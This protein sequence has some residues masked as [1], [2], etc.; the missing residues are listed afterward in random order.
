[1][2]LYIVTPSTS[3]V[4]IDSGSLAAG[5]SAI[6]LLSSQMPPGR[7]VT[8]RDSTGY[9]STPQS[10]IVSTTTGIFFA[11]GTSSIQI[12]QP[13]ASLS[14]TSRSATSWNV[15]NTFG[16]PLYNTV[17]NVNSLTASTITGTTLTLGG[18]VS[19]AYFTANSLFLQSTTQVLGAAFVS[20]LVVGTQ[21]S[22]SIPYQ[23]TPGYAAY[24]IGSAQI[25]SNAVFGGNLTVG[26]SAQ[27]Q[28]S[29]IVSGNLGVAQSMTV[30]AD[31]TIQGNLNTIGNGI[32]NAQTIN[33]QSS[34]SIVGPAIF[35]SNL[36]V[37]SNLQVAGTTTLATLGTST[38]NIN[39][40]AGGFLQL[41]SGPI[42][43]SV[44]NSTGQVV[45]SW[46]A[47]IY[48]PYLS[49]GSVQATTGAT[50]G[51]LQV[52]NTI[53]AP[54][55]S[56]VV[57]GSANIQNNAGSLTISS[58]NTN[59]LVLSNNIVAQ[60]FTASTL[61]ASTI[62]LGGSLIGVSPLSQLSTA[63]A[64]TS[65][66]YT[67]QLS[68]GALVAGIIVSPAVTVSSLNVGTTIT[69]GNAF[70]TLN[71]PSTSIVNQGGTIRTSALFTN[72]LTTST[73]SIDTGVIQ[74][75]SNIF[76]QAPSVSM[77]NAFISSLTTST[78]TTSTINAGRIIVGAPVTTDFRGPSFLVSGAASTNVVVSGGP[79]DYL[80]PYFLS[81][82]RPT[83]QNPAVAYTTTIGFVANQAVPPGMVVSYTA[84]LYWAS[85]L[86]S[87][88]SIAGGP[89]LYGTF[90][91]DQSA[92]GTLAQST[93]QI[94]ATLFGN[95]A[96]NVSF[97]FDYSPTVN[98]IDSNAVV[99]MNN[100]M[101]RWNYAL[102]GTTIQNSLNDITTRNLY[103]YGSLTFAS[104]PRIKED[105]QDADL[106]RCYEI[107]NG[108]PLRRYKY[109][110]SY[111]STFQLADSHRLGFLATDLLPC[112]PKSVKV[113][114]TLFPQETSSLL[115]IDT[116]QVEMAHLGATKY[117][118]R[119]V[120]ELEA[121]L[122]RLESVSNAS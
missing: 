88:V 9:L 3:V 119:K 101:L 20:T 58:V 81:N 93:F 84:N 34:A 30:G 116:S 82:V 74:S 53:S 108:L 37:Q 112:F 44:T 49:T 111:C 42:L 31:L 91:S 69:G 45:A 68:T 6:V 56:Q 33:V 1:M 79:G 36:T 14:F 98:S 107:I 54:T 43:R 12:S 59:T 99:E 110:D 62:I 118:T 38:I 63:S 2:S 64:I 95:S 55:V 7:N 40:L 75:S 102:N 103:Y 90:A 21:P 25:Q 87:L 105:V 85:Q 10:V 104:D 86:G 61:I 106:E 77:N 115:T 4:L 114:E 109:I 18:N 83:G 19:T 24:I 100:G 27:F 80:T 97:R 117:L 121:I 35:N 13:Y 11:D 29:M 41:G 65:T 94:S 51:I 8:V 28:S 89:T 73:I 50:I 78:L 71:I 5:E 76:I 120:E 26:G 72:L 96:I 22:I 60:S 70:S 17:A 66:F 32:I 39:T 122:K 57:F 92:S 52:A 46:N 67:N 23:T 16:F 15:I 48:T 113:S 47:P